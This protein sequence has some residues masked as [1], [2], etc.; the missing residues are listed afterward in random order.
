MKAKT[1]LERW[2][3]VSSSM[4]AVAAA[5]PPGKEGF[6]PAEG[7]MALGEHV[8]HCISAER[9]VVDAFTVTP[10][11]WEW[12]KGYTLDNYPT[13][14]AILAAFDEQA[15][16]TRSFLES[17]SE[18]DLAQVVKMPWE[19]EWTV[20]RLWW[21]WI[22]HEAHHRGSLVVALRVAGV[23]PPDIWG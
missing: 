6:R 4:R 1:L 15:K 12:D 20:E 14:E 2:E 16:A 10:G 22:V 7:A 19:A 13:I 8:L 18:D 3:N 17:R 5:V 23:T 11:Q 21:E 9:T